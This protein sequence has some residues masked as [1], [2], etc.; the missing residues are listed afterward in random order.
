VQ[1]FVRGELFSGRAAFVTK[2]TAILWE[3]Q[4]RREFEQMQTWP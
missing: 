1:F 4:E 3:E 2:A